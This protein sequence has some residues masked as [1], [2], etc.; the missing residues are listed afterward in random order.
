ME[1]TI[2]TGYK[3]ADKFSLRS[4]LPGNRKNRDMLAISPVT[5]VLMNLIMVIVCLLALIPIYV[6]FI[7]S[8]TS[9]ASLT[10]NGY[11]LWPAQF[12]TVAYKFLFMQG[13]VLITAYMN[14]IV[15]TVAGTLMSVF[16]VAFYAYALSRD[17]FKFR[18]FFTFFAFFTMLFGGGL[19][20]YYMGTLCGRSS[21]L[22]RSAHSG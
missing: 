10:A 18:T 8:I 6:I 21:C 15:A 11:R 12:A 2:N 9:E 20:A 3:P 16:M 1:K 22:P 14:T 5:N 13:S 17:N 7:S 19:V 4:L